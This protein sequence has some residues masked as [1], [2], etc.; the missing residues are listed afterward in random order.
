MKQR[1][2]LFYA[3]PTKSFGQVYS[4]CNWLHNIILQEIKKQ[5]DRGDCEEYDD[6]DSEEDD[7]QDAENDTIAQNLRVFCCSAAEYQ[8]LKFPSTND[9]PP[10]VRTLYLPAC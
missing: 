6:Y 10:L 8:K 9:G 7:E 5:A 3:H 4:F 2:F 1:Q